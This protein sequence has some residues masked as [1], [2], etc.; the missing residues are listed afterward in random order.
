MGKFNVVSNNHN[1]S[2]SEEIV[3]DAPK[4]KFVF[5]RNSESISRPNEWDIMAFVDENYEV[6]EFKTD[7]KKMFLFGFNRTIREKIYSKCWSPELYIVDGLKEC[8]ANLNLKTEKNSNYWIANYLM[9]KEEHIVSLCFEEDKIFLLSNS[10]LIH[11]GEGSGAHYVLY[12][13]SFSNMGE[14]LRKREIYMGI[15]FKFTEKQAPYLDAK[16]VFAW[17][18]KIYIVGGLSRTCENGFDREDYILEKNKNKMR[19]K[20]RRIQCPYNVD[21]PH[22][23]VIQCSGY[24]LLYSLV[25]Q[26][27]EQTQMT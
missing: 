22:S 1:L 25:C 13:G 8:I 26:D 7:S 12:E 5:E 24:Y 20:T 4:E 15:K 9:P 11:S 16:T 14:V 6:N 10:S 17:E 21:M 23:V 27:T 3:S 19:A 18:E 2:I